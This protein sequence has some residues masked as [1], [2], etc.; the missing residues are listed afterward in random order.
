MPEK[1]R[2][3]IT[4]GKR[5]PKGLKD[6]GKVRL[7]CADCGRALMEFQIVRNN[8]DMV[9]LDGSPGPVMTVVQAKCGLCGGKSYQRTI[10]GQFHYG[11]ADDS[12]LC[13]YEENAPEGCNVAFNVRSKR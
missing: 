13:E 7:E 5:E 1:T 12:L 10:E 11:P 9:K 3:E 8:A 4:K 2:L 6:R